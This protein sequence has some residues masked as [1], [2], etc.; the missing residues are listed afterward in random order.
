MNLSDVLAKLAEGS[1]AGLIGV[2]VRLGEARQDVLRVHRPLLQ[3][4]FPVLQ[5]S[6]EF[7]G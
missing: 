6:F 5:L 7:P 3:F 4:Q 2:D 1:G